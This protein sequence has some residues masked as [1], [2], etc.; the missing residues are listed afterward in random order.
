MRCWFVGIYYTD[1]WDI[2]IFTWFTWEFTEHSPKGGNALIRGTDS[3]R[4]STERR[5]QAF[6]SKGIDDFESLIWRAD[7]ERTIGRSRNYPQRHFVSHMWA[8]ERENCETFTE[9][10]KGDDPKRV[11]G[12]NL[13]DYFDK[14]FCQD[15]R[16]NTYAK[17]SLCETSSPR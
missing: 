2:V 4:R 12:C 14:F 16:P 13:R 10:L 1:F 3:Y 15:F 5:N 17:M 6:D 8:P 9:V 7:G 11:D